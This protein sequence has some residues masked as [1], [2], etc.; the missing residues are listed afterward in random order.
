MNYLIIGAGIAGT[1]AAETIR[2]HDPHALITILTNEAYPL[3]SRI[4]VPVYATGKVSKEHM[5]L[6][7]MEHF[8]TKHIAFITHV[9]TTSIDR[10]QKLVSYETRDQR[11]H[12]IRYDKLLIATGGTP[13]PVKIPGSDGKGI[14]SMHFLDD[15][16]DIYSYAK[17]KKHAVISG[18]SFIGM[19]FIDMFLDF[20]IPDIELLIKEPWF[21]YRFLRPDCA[22]MIHDMC[23]QKGIRIHT[24][25]NIT[26]FELDEDNAVYKVQT[27]K[28]DIRCDIVGIGHGI[29]RISP[30]IASSGLQ[31]NKGVITNEYMQTTDPS[32]FA[33]GDVAEYYAT[34]H[35]TYITAGDWVSARQ[36]GVSAAKN[37]VGM[38]TPYAD[39]A[40]NTVDVF[41]TNLT[42]T[43]LIDYTK[44]KTYEKADNHSYVALLTDKDNTV[45]GG[46]TLGNNEYS[47][48]IKNAIKHKYTATSID[49]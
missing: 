5:I 39:I 20:G 11:T 48:K 7:K 49:L 12:S 17:D 41:G 44:G 27:N 37:M 31:Y 34:H 18:G 14:F 13:H 28:E 4:T 35:G 16:T 6:R 23:I 22:F 42:I 25:T 9:H 47:Q 8:E 40:S 43:G 33:A 24:E 3:Y 2:T 21:L 36:Q 29:Q 38:T 19:D 45:I 32:I 15:G 30:F 1:T 46:I 26:A 10:E